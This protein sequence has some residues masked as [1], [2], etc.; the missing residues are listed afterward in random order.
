MLNV[1]LTPQQSTNYGFLANVLT[2][3][4]QGKARPMVAPQPA[5]SFRLLFGGSKKTTEAQLAVDPKQR[6]TS[7][8]RIMTGRAH[9]KLA[10]DV[11]AYLGTRL[12]PVDIKNHPNGE[13]D[14]RIKETVRGYDV[15][16]IQSI[17]PPTNDNLME[18][19]LIIDGLKRAKA[20]SITAVIPHYAY[21]R[22]DRRADG[23]TP[24][25]AK[26][27]ADMLTTA[28]ANHIITMD[29]HAS[30]LEGFFN[31]PVDNMPATPLTAGYVGLKN[32]KNLVV[33]SPDAGGV[34]R[35]R[36]FAEK[37]GAP[38]AIVDKRR[39][40]NNEAESLT[41]I[42]NVKGKV[43]L[44]IDDMIDTAGTMCEA[45]RMLME[46]GAKKVLAMGTH[47]LLS[48]PAIKRLEESVIDEVI[49]TDT[50]PLKRNAKKLDKLSQITIAPIIGE[51]IGRTLD[52][53]SVRELAD[54]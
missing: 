27:I 28:G 41:V 39:N 30:Q 42:G 54:K 9:P 47:G 37:L 24:I 16:V 5:D 49:V 52:D 51:A 17:S 25:P 10:K 46:H 48:G 3:G 7:K 14:V 31:I 11:A 34:K 19:L 6:N 53:Q 21:A 13:I 50:L 35:A 23:R 1:R 26:L 29:L 36:Q 22:G 20:K 40:E 45:A 44:I 38:Y 15:F 8:I 2:I 18:L 32:L 43:A 33:I 12:S 4:A